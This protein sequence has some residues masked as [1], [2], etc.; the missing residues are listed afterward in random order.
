VGGN[1]SEGWCDTLVGQLAALVL[2]AVV[3]VF[4]TGGCTGASG[5]TQDYPPL[6]WRLPRVVAPH[7]A[8]RRRHSAILSKIPRS[9]CCKLF[10]IGLCGV[11]Q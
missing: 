2:H 5:A 8:V 11:V 9:I 6:R 4:N 1:S 10:Q 3:Y 7:T